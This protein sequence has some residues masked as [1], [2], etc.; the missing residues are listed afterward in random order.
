MRFSYWK[1]SGVSEFVQ[2]RHRLQLSHELH[3]R[4]SDC[5]CCLL[6]L[7]RGHFLI[8]CTREAVLL[9]LRSTFSGEVEESMI[10]T[11]IQ[12]LAHL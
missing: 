1:I 4:K 7:N 9:N 12:C 5:L 10:L 8:N 11:I 2:E 6:T 3:P